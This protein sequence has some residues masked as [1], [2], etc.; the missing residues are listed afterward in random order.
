MSISSPEHCRRMVYI[1]NTELA[2]NRVAQRVFIY[3]LLCLIWF[4]FSTQRKRE[5]EVSRA[6]LICSFMPYMVYIFNTELTRN[7]AAQSI[8]LYALLCLVW[9]MFST[10]GMLETMGRRFRSN[11]PTFNDALCRC[12]KLYKE[13]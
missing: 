5:T 9:F 8:F 11:T 10:Q 7:R 12:N 1:F 6:F 2:R 4:I 13:K 3:A